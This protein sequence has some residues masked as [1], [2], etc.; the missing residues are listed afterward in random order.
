MVG[1][2]DAV[3]DRGLACRHLISSLSDGE[4]C[5]VCLHCRAAPSA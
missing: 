3:T 4:V 2:M 1:G 5:R